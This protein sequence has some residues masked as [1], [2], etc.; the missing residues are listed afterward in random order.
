MMLL[1][2]IKKR[3]E[4]DQKKSCKNYCLCTIIWHSAQCVQSST[5]SM[6]VP[7]LVAL[8]NIS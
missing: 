5:M 1:Q 7:F 2:Y 8:H 6:V 3:K 4:T